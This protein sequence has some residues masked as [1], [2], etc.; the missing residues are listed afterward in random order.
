MTAQLIVAL[1]LPNVAAARAVIEEV[2]DAADCWKI[3]HQLA[4]AAGP[5]NGLLLAQELARGGESVFLDL[6][7]LDIPNTVAEGVRSVAD[8]GVSMLTV[9]AYPQAMK[10]AATAAKGTGLAT[11]AVT[12]LTSMDDRDLR[13]AGYAGDAKELVELRARQAREAGMGGIVASGAEAARVKPLVGDMAVVTPGI[14]PTDAARGDQKRVATPG[15]A[16]RDGATHLVVGRPITDA[17]DKRAAAL[18]IREEMNG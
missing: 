9:H 17:H 12:V 14:R 3:G 10:A 7:L 6:K 4:F 8:M 18:A 15:E 2:G 1:D 13:G 5:E 16:V 11:L